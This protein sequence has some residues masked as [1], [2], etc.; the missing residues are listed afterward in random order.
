MM[1]SKYTKTG[2]D[3][4]GLFNVHPATVSRILARTGAESIRA[5]V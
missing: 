2:A 3:A 5:T 1:V 4:A